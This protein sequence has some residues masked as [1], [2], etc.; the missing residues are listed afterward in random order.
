MHRIY[1]NNSYDLTQAPKN[2]G[3][4]HFPFID[5]KK[6]TRAKKKRKEWQDS[7]L[8]QQHIRH[9]NSKR[10]SWID[11][12][13]D[14]HQLLNHATNAR[15]SETKKNKTYKCLLPIR[16]NFEI[17]SQRHYWMHTKSKSSWIFWQNGQSIHFA[18]LIS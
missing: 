14:T 3:K 6:H 17:N 15:I 18:V 8:F 10:V 11:L 7:Q 4:R 1:S 5:L 9:L 12:L 2:E 16:K 13:Q